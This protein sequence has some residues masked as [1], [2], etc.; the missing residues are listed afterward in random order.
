MGETH[1]KKRREWS[2]YAVACDGVGI[3]RR[4]WMLARLD[5]EPLVKQRVG[6]KESEL[7]LASEYR[8]VLTCSRFYCKCGE[9]YTYGPRHRADCIHNKSLQLTPEMAIWE[10]SD[11]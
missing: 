2:T 11:L 5:W 1:T 7:T 4:N 10:V 8:K 3:A 6:R 9:L